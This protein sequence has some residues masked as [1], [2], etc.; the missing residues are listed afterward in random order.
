MS[1]T[2]RIP[3]ALAAL[4]VALGGAGCNFV[5]G[6]EDHE[7]FPDNCGAAS[8][9]TARFSFSDEQN[10]HCYTLVQSDDAMD[11]TN[12]V[13]ARRSCAEAGG[14]LACVNDAD[15]LALIAKSVPTRAWLGMNA[16][17]NTELRF[18]CISGERFDPNYDAWVEG[19]PTTDGGGSCSHLDNGL[20]RSSSCGAGLQN[21]L[22]ELEPALSEGD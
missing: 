6:L 7:G 19:H 20:V 22:C 2:R 12:F 13:D 4:A 10:G 14:M 16:L 3:S 17:T 21:W 9:T 8:I 11:G 15:E 18:S 1:A 5:L